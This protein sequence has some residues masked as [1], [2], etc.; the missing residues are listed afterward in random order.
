MTSPADARREIK[1]LLDAKYGRTKPTPIAA[2][3]GKDI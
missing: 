1:A 2:M 3:V